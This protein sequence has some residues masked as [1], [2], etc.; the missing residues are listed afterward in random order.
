[1]KNKIETKNV[2]DVILVLDWDPE[3]FHNRVS[4]L[5]SRGYLARLDSYSVTADMNPETGSIIH[6][7]SI[8]MGRTSQSTK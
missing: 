6:L 3:S 1:M 4:E 5:E 7:Y 2:D 8:E